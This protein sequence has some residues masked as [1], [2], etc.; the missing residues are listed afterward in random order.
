MF[1]GIDDKGTFDP[2][3]AITRGQLCQ[4][5]YSMGWTEAGCY[6]YNNVK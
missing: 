1:S 6:N 4:V 5:L 3:G 2:Y